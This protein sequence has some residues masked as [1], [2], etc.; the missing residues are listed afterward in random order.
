MCIRD[1]SGISGVT[2]GGG[3][4]GIN[5]P[6]ELFEISAE[7]HNF[8]SRPISKPVL[9][10]QVILINNYRNKSNYNIVTLCFPLT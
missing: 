5:S 1:R 7:F 10:V 4:Q 6:P 2:C 8:L 3:Y 9:F